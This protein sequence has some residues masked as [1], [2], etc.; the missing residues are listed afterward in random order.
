MRKILII[1]SISFLLISC[2]DFFNS[3]DVINSPAEKYWKE[4]NNLYNEEMI[5]NEKISWAE[6]AVF[7]FNQINCLPELSDYLAEFNILN[8]DIEFK[9]YINYLISDI[10]WKNN[11]VDLTVYYLM[12][13]PKEYYHIKFNNQEIGYLKGLR[14][15]KLD[16]FSGVKEE[17]YNLL[18]T[19]Y[20]QEIDKSAVLYDMIS[21]YKS[22]YQID[23]A[24]PVMQELIR[25][26]YMTRIYD[27]RIN[28][29]DLQEEVDFYYSNKSWIYK[30]LNYLIEKIKSAIRR[31]D[32]IDL[33]RYVSKTDFRV[34]F[35][36]KS[37]YKKWTFENIGIPRR[38]H[39]TIIFSKEFEEISN[40]N[41]VYLRTDNWNFPQMR[42]WYFYFKKID[43]P[44]DTNIDGGWEWQAIYF[45]SW[46]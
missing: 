29:K 15:I 41:E 10:Y 19:D 23:K 35:F 13:I 37:A 26:C 40:E 42:T 24:I 11:N 3:Y 21:F 22:E 38:W 44:Y 28:L 12:L 31:K 7:H 2:F 46:Y 45:G 16:G 25:Y 18:R 14:L 32:Y 33:R 5:L 34:S 27:D 36:R 4:M 1:F 17:M 6:K 8:S 30:D 43:Y 39:S 20:E 9:M